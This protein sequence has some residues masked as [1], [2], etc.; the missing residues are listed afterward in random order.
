VE[1]I[2]LP[3]FEIDGPLIGLTIFLLKFAQIGAFEKGIGKAAKT[4]YRLLPPIDGELI[5]FSSDEKTPEWAQILQSQLQDA[6]DLTLT[7]QSPSALLIV[8]RGIQT[9]VMSFGHAWQKLKPEWVEID[10][11]LRVVLNSVAKDRLIEV[12]AEQVFAKWHISSERAP[13]ASYIRDFGVE[14]DRDLLS[15]LEGIP[16]KGSVLGQKIRGGTSLRVDIPITKLP[17]ILDHASDVF[18]SEEYK[19]RWPELGNI[20]PVIDSASVEKLDAELDTKL[21]SGEALKTIVLFTPE[22]KRGENLSPPESYAWGK[23]TKTHATSPYLLLESWLTNL[24]RSGEQPSLETSKKVRINLLDENH[25]RIKNYRVYDCFCYELGLDEQQYILSSGIW[26]RIVASFVQEVNRYL[27][28]IGTPE[29]ALPA[30]NQQIREPAYNEYCAKELSFLHFDAKNIIFGENYSKFEFCD[31]LDPDGKTLYFVK[32]ASKASAM[33]HLVEQVRRTAELLFSV[34]QTY[35]NALMEVYKKYHPKA[36]IKW[37]K[38]RPNNSD[39][40]LCLVSM[41]RNAKNLPFFAKCGLRRLHKDLT[42]RG[43]VVSFVSV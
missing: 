34:D 35:R 8:R 22:Q 42:E 33:S 39:W 17:A 5:P 29:I 31:F 10:F 25:T 27:D 13:R 23:L 18:A 41:G 20:T 36:D 16:A 1:V 28:D 19:K 9:F 6:T 2:S 24:T 15:T 40:H 12:R 14:F 3:D 38:S 21:Q 26:Y 7:A 30:W 43:H 4:G 32:I 37:L 11:G